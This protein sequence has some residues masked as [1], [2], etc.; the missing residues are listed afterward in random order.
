[1]TKLLVVYEM[2]K[3]WILRFVYIKK[4]GG[5]PS[6]FQNIL[7][8]RQNNKYKTRSEKDLIEPL[9]IARKSWKYSSYGKPQIW[10]RFF[11]PNNNLS[12]FKPLKCSRKS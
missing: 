2:N 8:Q 4:T 9:C 5:M 3:H 7:A 6:A 1:M 11:A 12:N 10:N